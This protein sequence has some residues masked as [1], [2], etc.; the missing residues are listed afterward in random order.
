MKKEHRCL[1]Y[2]MINNLIIS[3]IKVIGGV[4]FKINSLLADGMHTFSDFIT[5][6]IS[7]VGLKISRKKPTKT[8][9]FGFGKIAY[10]TN[11]FVGVVIF[12]LGCFIIISGFGKEGATPSITILYLL[13]VVFVLKLMAIIVMHRVGKKINSQTLITSTRESMA[14]LYSTIGVAIITIL[15]QFKDKWQ[16]LRYADLVGTVLIGI[17][18]IKTSIL[19]IVSN[20]LSLIGEVETSSEV[21][22][23]LENFI[24]DFKGVEACRINLIK[25]GVYYKLELELELDSK[26]SLKQ[27]TNLES[28]IKRQII[29]HRSFNVKYVDVY[30]ADKLGDE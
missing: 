22:S 1:L 21:I 8:H 30:V 25:Y 2:S 11:L 16:L 9:P 26:L 12:L 3:V 24:K 14:D 7:F 4:M 23:R 18:V 15:L 13:L 27:I 10:L 17:I 29:R 5:D 6:V 19:V 20:S 28:K